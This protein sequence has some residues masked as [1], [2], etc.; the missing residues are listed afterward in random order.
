MRRDF[1]MRTSTFAAAALIALM[2]TSAS[3]QNTT[4]TTTT[5]TAGQKAVTTTHKG[6]PPHGARSEQS[7]ACSAS[8][9]SKNIHGKD[10]QKF[11][12]QCKKSGGKS[13]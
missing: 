1:D 4:T 9:D 10:R 2:A 7:L 8:A 5:K 11:M 13:A 12:R 3:A 6:P